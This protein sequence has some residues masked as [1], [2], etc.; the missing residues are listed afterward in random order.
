MSWRKLPTWSNRISAPIVA[1]CVGWRDELR[2]GLMRLVGWIGV[3]GML[4]LLAEM[5]P[6]A[7][8]GWHAR[9][10]AANSGLANNSAPPGNGT[11]HSAAPLPARVPFALAEPA[12]ERIDPEEAIGGGTVTAL[13]QDQRGLL[14]IGSQRG[15][16][17]YDGYRFQSF[18]HDAHRQGSLPGNFVVAL[19]QGADGKIWVGTDS[20]GLARF[21]PQSGQFESFRHDP[22]QPDSISGGTIWAMVAGPD[23]GLWIATDGGL[24]Y[25]PPHG[26]GFVHLRHAPTRPGSLA[27]DQVRSLLLDR[28]S[29]LWVGSYGGLQRLS[30]AQQQRAMR[31][32][33]SGRGA[34]A[35]VGPAAGSAPASGTEPAASADFERITL[36]AAMLGQ[37]ITSL[38]QAQDGKLWIGSNKQGAAWLA[39]G[40]GQWHLLPPASGA[41]GGSGAVGAAGDES[42]LSHGWIIAISQVNSEQIWLATALGGINVVSASDGKVLQRLRHD[43]ALPSSLALDDMGALLLDR[44]GWLWVGTWG[45]GLQ[46]YNANNRAFSVLRHSPTRPDSLSHADVHSA[47]ELADGKILIGSSGNGIDIY[48]RQRGVIGGY[49]ARGDARQLDKAPSK[50]SNQAP[51]KGL[52]KTAVAGRNQAGAALGSDARPPA[53]LPDASVYALAQSADGVVW[54]GT[55]Q[56]GVARLVSGADG[57]AAWHGTQ[58][59]PNPKVNRLLAGAGE[60]AVWAGTDDGLARWQGERFE[61]VPGADG[62]SIGSVTALVQEPGGRLWVGSNRGLWLLEPGAAR[63]RSIVHDAARA[64][65]LVSNVVKGL[66]LDRQ[67][68]LWVNTHQGLERMRSFENGVARFEHISAMLGV[69]GQ[70]LGGNM[71]QDRL[72]RIWVG[73]AVIEI[74]PLRM[75]ELSKIDGF[76][77]GGAWSG[78]STDTRDGWFLVGGATGLALIDSAA[79]VPWQEQPALVVTD[80]K[81]NGKAAA[82][83][84]LTGAQ[85]RLTLHP[86][87]RHFSIEFA[88]LDYSQPRRN[89]YRYQL[90]GYDSEWIDTDYEHRLAAY[91][92]LWP[93]H[94][95]L[96]VQGSNRL[97]QWSAH[98][99]EITITVLPAF[100]QTGWCMALFLLAL[101]SAIG[102]GYRWRL[103][104]LQLRTRRLEQVVAERTA[105]I[106]AAHDQLAASHR[107]LQET[108]AQLIESGKMATLGQLVANVAHEINTPIGAVKGSSKVIAD[109]Y[110][111]AL[112]AVPQLIH[113][114]NPAQLALFR[115]LLACAVRGDDMASTRQLR[116]Q[117]QTLQQQLQQAGV[118]GAERKASALAHLRVYPALS[119]DVARWL[120]LLTHEQADFIL[121]SAQS[122]ALIHNHTRN[123]DQALARMSKIVYALTSFLPSG[124]GS[125]RHMS[126]ADLDQGIDTVLTIYQSRMQQGVKLVRQYQ[127]LPAVPCYPDELN[128]VW[129][130]LIQNALQAM[131]YQG[132]LTISVASIG[133]EAVVAISDTGCGIVPA[134]RERIFEPFFTTRPVGEGSG[135]G[136]DLVRKIVA[137][138]H[139]RIS[140]DSTPD[141]G[142][143]FTVFLP[144]RQEQT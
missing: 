12:F 129:N 81:I 118:M 142:S 49:R 138:H 101:G 143:T 120:P 114:L 92:N 122:I 109:G 130:N 97:G 28:Q 37:V 135:L 36:P 10:A 91:G 82:P 1:R 4:G 43:A 128:Q 93:G 34:A 121:K 16:V 11:P 8:G 134:I 41:P 21:D 73:Y 29:Q 131:Q 71:H 20:D 57:A 103:A 22:A 116:E 68:H 100:W 133:A 51:N 124:S 104:K 137:R 70:N 77:N 5:G 27:S 108:Q 31:A 75:H 139:G 62:K 125:E 33:G 30:L 26:T 19:A 110:A 96:R 3:L 144:L 126:G 105:D 106:S 80:L 69:V 9:A 18:V 66:L 95:R 56:A 23:G 98:E 89:R 83:G 117:S 24:D 6:G 58:G 40:S 141:Q 50:E 47:L 13:L 2:G 85:P 64:D 115:A 60:N 76:D 42:G 132:T 140:V 123:I 94:Y 15:L 54:A 55:V 113:I 112:E 88:A 39:P 102:F 67:G 17:R 63:L 25:R 84:P 38:F 65:S 72:G 99:L 136:L 111:T 35:G 107:E 119:G 52:G 87:Q 45:G 53:T 79:F 127:S 90:Q 14:W 32:A 44:S 46:R 7:S 78:A 48:D 61:V 86:E 74:N 59:L